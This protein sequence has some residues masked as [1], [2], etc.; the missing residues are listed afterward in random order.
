[1]KSPVLLMA[2]NRVEE[3][4]RVLHAI[5]RYEPAQLYLA[6]D[7]PRS[8]RPSEV[9]RHAKVVRMLDHIDWDCEVKRLIRDENLGCRRAVEGAIDWFF[10][11]VP[12]GIILEDDC[13]P[14]PD[15]FR[16][17][18]ALLDR[19]RDDERVA[20]VSGTNVL[21]E[22]R[23]NDASYFFGYGAVWGW[24]SWSRAWRNS[25]EHL[26]AFRTAEACANAAQTVGEG[27]WRRLETSMH[28]VAM[29]ELDTWDYPWV[30]ALA[31]RSQ[32]AALP[33]V[34]LV[35]N[36]GFGRGATHTTTEGGALGGLRVLPLE[37]PMRH[38]ARVYFDRE[39]DVRWQALEASA[40]G[41]WARL[42]RRLRVVAR[43][44]TGV[45][46]GSRRRHA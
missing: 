25:A 3:L 19:Y 20:M 7:G 43:R 39:F 30:F 9:V 37:D 35:S 28:A 31:A 33:A 17:C 23:A 38:P 24:A 2:F 4:S 13:V 1:M 10:N 26:A 41:W 8:D 22:W 42:P 6:V 36:I 11:S 40:A 44:V 27:R 5:R 14:S 46:K 32:L 21:G 15:F 29:G 12:E 34:N 45:V 16:F 18:E